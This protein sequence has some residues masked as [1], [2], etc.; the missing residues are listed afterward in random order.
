MARPG[1]GKDFEVRQQ[2][3]SMLYHALPGHAWV[4]MNE[5]R[6]FSPNQ[7]ADTSEY[8]RI[9]DPV[10]KKV[11][12]TLAIDAEVQVYVEDNLTEVAAIMSGEVRPGGGWAGTEVLQLDTTVVH[13]FK[14]ENYD[15]IDVG[16]SLLL[17]TEY[18][19]GW[20]ASGMGTPLEAEGDVR[21]FSFPGA[22]SSYYIVPVAGS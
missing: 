14:V 6:L 11:A 13:N 12:N 9:G 7:T 15:G 18:L 4:L 19:S 21:I 10:K 22:A 16:S 3:L 2:Y 17:N 1:F 5:G 20:Q 8:S